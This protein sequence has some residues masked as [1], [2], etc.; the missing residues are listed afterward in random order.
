MALNHISQT[1][2]ASLD[3]QAVLD[4]QT[5]M[6]EMGVVMRCSR[7]FYLANDEDQRFIVAYEWCAPGVVP[8]RGTSSAW[9][10]VPR[11]FRQ[12]KSGRG[13]G[14]GRGGGAGAGGRG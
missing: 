8:V 1:I 6:N 7:A 12:L 4:L 5:A 11:L 9:T 2:K 14:G 3:P 10:E 13:L